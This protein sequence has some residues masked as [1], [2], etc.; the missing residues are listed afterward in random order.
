VFI[1]TSTHPAQRLLAMMVHNNNVSAHIS[2]NLLVSHIAD[3]VAD[4]ILAGW[5]TI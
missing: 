4:N 1:Y 2:S 5:R 3:P